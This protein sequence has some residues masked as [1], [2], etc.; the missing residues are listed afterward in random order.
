MNTPRYTLIE[1]TTDHGLISAVVKT[2][3]PGTIV[4]GFTDHDSCV[5]YL[6]RKRQRQ[7]LQNGEVKA[8]PV[9]PGHTKYDKE[10]DTWYN[11]FLQ[12]IDEYVTW[13][14]VNVLQCIE[15]K[16]IDH[17]TITDTTELFCTRGSKGIVF[18]RYFYSTWGGSPSSKSTLDE[19]I[20]RREIIELIRKHKEIIINSL[21]LDKSFRK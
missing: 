18:T 11:Q 20:Y 15:K 6:R 1:Y 21:K 14:R 8:I 3:T 16:E 13:N 10:L 12:E 5:S 9:L 19:A 2:D 17:C 7:Y 4:F